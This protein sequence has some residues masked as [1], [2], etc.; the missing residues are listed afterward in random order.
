MFLVTFQ[1]ENIK[2]FLWTNELTNESTL[3]ASTNLWIYIM[4]L[5]GTSV[6]HELSLVQEINLF[7]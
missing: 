7:Y 5:F 2:Y 3:V 4:N 6:L 1:K